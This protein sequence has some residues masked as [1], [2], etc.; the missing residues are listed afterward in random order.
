MISKI[1]VNSYKKLEGLRKSDREILFLFYLP[2][3]YLFPPLFLV[4]WADT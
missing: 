4:S 1:H 3:L 2:F